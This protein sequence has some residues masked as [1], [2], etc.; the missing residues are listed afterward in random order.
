MRNRDDDKRKIDTHVL[1]SFFEGRYDEM[2]ALMQPD[3]PDEELV[4]NLGETATK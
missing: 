1:Q 3:E 4:C 2:M